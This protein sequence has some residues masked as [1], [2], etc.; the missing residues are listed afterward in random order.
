MKL[1]LLYETVNKTKK[2]HHI[3]KRYVPKTLTIKDKKY[4]LK[5]IKKSR[6][7]YKKGKYFDRPKIKSFKN[8]KSGHVDNAKK[9]YK[10]E[11][12]NANPELSKKTGCSMSNPFFL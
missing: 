12:I 7:L 5:N 10:T 4:Q 2:R 8:K 3:P 6:N 9:I 11:I 1:I